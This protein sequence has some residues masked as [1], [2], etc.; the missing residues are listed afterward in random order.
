M[1][2]KLKLTGMKVACLWFLVG[3]LQQLLKKKTFQV[4]TK[5]KIF[6]ILHGFKILTA[7]GL[8]HLRSPVLDL[9]HL[10]EVRDS[11]GN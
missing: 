2:C 6:N 7:E 9:I 3:Q 5:L 11:I 8:L 1:L 10:A 4:K